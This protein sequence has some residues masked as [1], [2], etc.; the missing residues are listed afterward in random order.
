MNLQQLIR[1]QRII[2]VKI[3]QE[4]IKR[5]LNKAHFDLREAKKAL[6]AQVAQGA[7]SLAYQAVLR[8]A[9]VLMFCKGFKPSGDGQHKTVV[10]FV[11][12]FL[13][14][15]AVSLIARFDAMRKKRHR[16]LY[17]I[18]FVSDTEAE[19]ALKSASKLLRKIEEV[20]EKEMGQRRLL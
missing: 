15:S 20:I 8:A 17:E 2:P 13:G 3:G 18:A 19:A 12:I 11:D 14:K 4:Q 6:Q 9:R 5:H 7:F 10:E 16:L 1:N